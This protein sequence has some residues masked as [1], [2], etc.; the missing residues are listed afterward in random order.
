MKKIA[1]FVL[2]IVISISLI[3]LPV[4]FSL[5]ATDNAP[6]LIQLGE[7]ISKL[8]SQGPFAITPGV[9][10]L[11]GTRFPWDYSFGR[12]NLRILHPRI[13]YERAK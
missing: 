10:I 7:T 11:P 1:A 8:K 9:K 12:G 4:A 6:Q 3:K 2:S 13:T 5:T